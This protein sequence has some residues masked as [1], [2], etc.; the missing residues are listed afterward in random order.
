MSLSQTTL[1][2]YGMRMTGETQAVTA[3]QGM[4][5]LGGGAGGARA[6]LTT[7]HLCR[8]QREES[9]KWNN[10]LVVSYNVESMGS[11]DRTSFS[12]GE[13]RSRYSTFDGD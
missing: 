4:V 12:N 1:D 9:R 11:E 3:T 2:R 6:G 7:G 5:D 13:K 8:G 10:L